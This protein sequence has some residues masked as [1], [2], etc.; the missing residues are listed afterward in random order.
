MKATTIRLE[1]SVLNRVDS[2]EKVMNRSRT[3]VINQAI[4]C[5]LSYE[6]WFVHEV[7]AGLDEAANE[8]LASDKKVAECFARSEGRF[9]SY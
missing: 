5:F 7:N 2:M 4:Q 1:N 3:W 6:E 8:D 9:R